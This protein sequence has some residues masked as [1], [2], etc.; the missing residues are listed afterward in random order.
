MNDISVPAPKKRERKLRLRHLYSDEAASLVY[1]DGENYI[2]EALEEFDFLL[3][4]FRDGSTHPIDP[5]LLD[6]LHALFNTLRVREPAGIVCG[7]R[8]PRSNALLLASGKGGA[9]RSLHLEG[10]AIDIRM[11]TRTVDEIARA[12]MKLQRGGVGRYSRANFVH[13]DT[14][15]FRT[16]GS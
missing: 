4:D 16:W 14:G 7:Y 9:K 6:Y 8:S 10:R 12:A 1:Y 5:A 11:K 15:P 13:I 2:P 3:R